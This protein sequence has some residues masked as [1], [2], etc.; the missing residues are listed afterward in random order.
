LSE[1]LARELLVPHHGLQESENL[2]AETF[3]C[4]G[5]RLLQLSTLVVPSDSLLK[6][7]FIAS[8]GVA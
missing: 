6:P 4:G 5:R 2:R 8:H 1:N 7:G 3:D